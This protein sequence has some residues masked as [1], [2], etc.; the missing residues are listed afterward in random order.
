MGSW[1]MTEVLKVI[2]ILCVNI[3]PPIK[4]EKNTRNKSWNPLWQ[5]CSRDEE[6]WTHNGAFF[7]AS[8]GLFRWYTGSIAHIPG[9]VCG[10]EYLEKYSSPKFIDSLDP[11]KLGL[12]GTSGVHLALSIYLGISSDLF[13]NM[14]DYQQHIF[15]G[16]I[17]VNICV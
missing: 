3:W 6:K 17:S 4:G 11:R 8:L 9:V 12:Q 10:H 5:I 16:E 2:Q 7:E 14:L 15:L 1:S 13:L